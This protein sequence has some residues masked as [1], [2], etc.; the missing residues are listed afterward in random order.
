MLALE[1]VSFEWKHAPERGEQI[2]LIAQQVEEVVPQVVHEADRYSDNDQETKYKRVDYD[3][4]VPLL[5]DSIKV[6]TARIE[7]LEAKL[8]DK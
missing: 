1:S 7:E 4:I 2:G 6:L 8:E 5:V 3:K